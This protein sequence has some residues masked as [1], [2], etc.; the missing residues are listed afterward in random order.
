MSFRAFL[1]AA[2]LVAVAGFWLG[3]SAPTVGQYCEGTVYG[4]SGRYNLATG[5]G[6]LAVRTWPNSSSRMIGQLFNGDHTEIFDRR[7][8]WVEIGG[9]TGWANA[10]WLRNDC[11]Y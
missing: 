3:S 5:S 2:A 6:F 7:G 4:L 1:P 10:R 8:N 9:G 11:G